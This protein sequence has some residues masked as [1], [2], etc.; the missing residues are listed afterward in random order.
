M[1]V[2]IDLFRHDRR[3]LIG[4]TVVVFAFALS[5]VALVST[6]DVRRIIAI[7]KDLPPSLNHILGTTSMGQDI[8][9]LGAHGIKNSYVL[10]MMTGLWAAAVGVPVGLLAGY[11][12]GI[13]DRILMSLNDALLTIPSL[14]IIMLL[15]FIFKDT[16]T[17][18]LLSLMI[19]LFSWPWISRQV[20]SEILSL[21]ERDFTS[22]AV[23]SG[24]NTGQIAVTQHLPFVIPF[25]IAHFINTIRST[26]SLEIVLALFGLT[27][28][29][30]PTIGTMIY[31]ANQYQAV[32]RGLWWWI[33]TPIV[34]TIVTFLG[35]YLLSNS[36]ADFL[37]P[38]TRLE[39]IKV[40]I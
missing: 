22:T 16:M 29:D 1:R 8:F 10:G 18:V 38:R 17:L 5:L 33:G 28:L 14:P 19:S 36:I 40:S 11:K 27:S 21:R 37:D 7:Q 3:A 39:V 12:G 15:G 35:L 31:W 30:T 6:H 9:L 26:I 25:V 24:M 32:L 2:L 4:G 23:F 20:R 13:V 34:L